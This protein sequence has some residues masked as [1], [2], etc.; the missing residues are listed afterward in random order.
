[1]SL[2]HEY[3]RRHAARFQE[4]LADLLKIPSVSTQPEHAADVQRAAEW[5]V[6]DM[7]RIGM[8]LAEIHQQ[9]DYLPLVYGEWSGAGP[10]APTLLLYTHYDVQPAAMEDG[11]TSDPF[12]PVVRDGRLYARGAVDSKS[13]VVAWL[14]AVE[15]L[16]VA[17][18]PCPVNIKILFEGEEES[19]SEQIF[20]FVA[21]NKEKLASD[22]II[23]SDG[24][25]SDENQPIMNYGLRGL[26]SLELTVTGPKR[27][28][29]SGHYGGTIH[30]PIQAL[31]EII[32]RLH[33]KDG[34]VTVP[35]F[36]D[37][38]R[39]LDDEERALLGKMAPL[40]QQEWKTVTGAA[41]AWGEPGHALHERIGTRPTLEINGIAGGFYGE[42]FKTVIPSKAWAKIS[43]R[44]VPDQ[45]PARIYRLIHDY[46]DQITPPTIQCEMVELEAGSEGILLDRSAPPM[47]AAAASYEKA[48][49][50][51]P[52][53][54][55]EG[56]SVPVVES[57]L[58]NLDAPVVTMPFGLK[59]GG[60]HGPNEFVV[61]EMFQKGIAA[62]I[63]F[64]QEFAAMTD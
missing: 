29:H 30:N 2:A 3:A 25:M 18:D 57:F 7:R 61:L 11:W 34:R 43:C 63:F 26:V 4:E 6:A 15:S 36:Y 54:T 27:D 56:G 48:W 41:A 20:E 22:V 37:N 58:K 39:D 19:G 32:A 52:L 49:G 28:L 23:I 47:K 8:T 16:L 10:D 21:S 60:A 62:A 9:G 40:V 17:D 42:G 46:I 13:H 31:S 44:L 50:V 5:I 33:D 38:V 24:S 35:G 14:K 64:A 51:T 1:M 53:F 45:D 12:V 59:E 55:R